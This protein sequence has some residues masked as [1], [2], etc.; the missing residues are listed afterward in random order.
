M[1]ECVNAGETPR[2]GEADPSREERCVNARMR[3][4]NWKLRIIDWGYRTLELPWRGVASSEDGS[5][6]RTSQSA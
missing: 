4:C 2:Q 5:H 3:E 6:F 1:R